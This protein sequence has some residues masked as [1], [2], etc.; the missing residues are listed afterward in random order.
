MELIIRQ[1]VV[2][3]IPERW[4]AQYRGRGWAEHDAITAALK[5]LEKPINAADA[6]A[7]IGNTSWTEFK[8]DECGKAVEALVQLGPRYDEGPSAWVCKK[9]LRAAL[10][11]L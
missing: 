7:I 8:C 9:C 5:A 6:A 1:E 10:K 11:L 3:S 2:D 4:E